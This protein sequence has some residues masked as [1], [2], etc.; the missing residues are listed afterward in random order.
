M[1]SNSNRETRISQSVYRLGYGLDDLG[2]R[3]RFPAE[4]VDFSVLHKV[5]TGSGAHLFSYTKGTGGC[6]PEGK[7]TGT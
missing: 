7:A 2:V 6:L 4:A 3:V 1:R 5:Q